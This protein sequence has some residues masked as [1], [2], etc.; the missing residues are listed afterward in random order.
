MKRYPFILIV[1]SMMTG[2]MLGYF[3]SSSLSLIYLM[4]LGVIFLI[5]ITKNP[6]L[7]AVLLL[8][9]FML[10]GLAGIEAKQ[11]AMEGKLNRF[12]R[13]N[14]GQ[15]V[16]I[17]GKIVSDVQKRET[18]TGE[19]MSFTLNVMEG[20]DAKKT[21]FL[22]GKV[23][24]QM[25][26]GR[27]L[28]YGDIIKIKGKMH[29]P[30]IYDKKSPS[31]YRQYLYFRGIEWIISV[32]NITPV[33]IIKRNR[34]NTLKTLMIALRLK[35]EEILEAHLSE[36]EAGILKAILLG[37]R[38]Q[39][40]KHIKGLFMQTGTTHVLVI[41]GLHIGVIISLI[42]VLVRIIPAGRTFQYIATIII[43]LAYVLMAGARP[44][45]LRATIMGIILLGG[46]IFEKKAINFNTLACAALVLLLI[47]PFYLFDVGFQLSFTCVSAIL[48]VSGR[49]S[50]RNKRSNVFWE[51]FWISLGVWVGVAG[52]IA[53]YFLIITPVT[54]LANI[55]VV[56]MLTA[57]VSVGTGMIILG[58]ISDLLGALF[59]V[60]TQ[61]LVNAMV[62]II[63]IFNEIPFGHFYLTNV[64][65]WHIIIYYLILILLIILIKTGPEPIDK[66]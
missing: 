28:S 14:Y 4:T 27:P 35:C 49:Q 39:L 33:E 29:R 51:S 66:A 7:N 43:L 18:T 38:S 63:Y 60:C 20:R 34:G 22:D 19:K 15:P 21:R 2:I 1:F 11:S 54:V 65:L 30:Y 59:G 32:K 58:S 52:L 55:I 24:V 48:F 12:A 62:G 45:I 25:F 16:E 44:S 56:P 17:V 10:I 47:N 13:F 53:Y 26:K 9:G 31:S 37:N 50:K 36:N 41:S 8:L 40:P 5:F 46:F 57:L 61:L 6:G 3:F 64:N 23:L 42:Y